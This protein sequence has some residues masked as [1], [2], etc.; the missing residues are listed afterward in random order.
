MLCFSCHGAPSLQCRPA[1]CIAPLLPWAGAPLSLE[2]SS[3]WFASPPGAGSSVSPVP[4]MA[5]AGC[6]LGPSSGCASLSV[7][8]EAGSG[9]G[10]VLAA[11]SESCPAAQLPATPVP[12][13]AAPQA[14]PPGPSSESPRSP[15]WSASGAAPLVL[16]A[17]ASAP[18]NL[19]PF[20]TCPPGDRGHAQAG[21][22]DF[23]AAMRA[24]VRARWS[25]QVR[26]GQVYY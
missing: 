12:A 5:R 23:A 16:V 19:E 25:G 7:A 1:L 4:L 14:S 18:S 26:S 3:Y 2:D 20:G 21:N 15:P 11:A 9:S 8:L 22:R 17:P 13:P 10:L 24:A 6:L